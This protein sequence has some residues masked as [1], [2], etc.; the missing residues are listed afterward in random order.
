MNVSVETITPEQ[1]SALLALNTHNRNLK[2]QYILRLAGA[3][4]RGEWE[5]NGE[6]IKLNGDTLVDGQHRLAAIVK[7]GVPITTVVVRDLP[8]YV[9]ETIDTGSRRTLSDTLKLRGE[10]N[11]TSLG[12]ALTFL[13]QFQRG[14]LGSGTRS[15]PTGKEALALLEANPTIRSYIT[16]GERAR[17]RLKLSV[18]MV[19]A[20]HFLF[21][22]IDAK[23][24]DDFFGKLVSGTNLVDGSPV[25]A[26]RRSIERHVAGHTHGTRKAYRETAACVIKAWNA[27]RD[28]TE[29]FRIRWTPGGANPEQF[30]VPR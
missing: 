12:T 10:P 13:Y 26:L 9:Q 1:A 27:Y 22:Q 2:D 28:G 23:D 19:A 24:A 8:L 4:Q 6:S 14:H 25:L 17:R 5:M 7:S 11:N 15:F 16:T 18:G 20:L 29:V 30:P 3:M 21:T